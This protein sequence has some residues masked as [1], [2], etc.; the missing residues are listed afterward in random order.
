MFILFWK[1][2][3]VRID[4]SSLQI[5]TY[6]KNVELWLFKIYILLMK[7]N[8]MSVLRDVKQGENY[9]ATWTPVWSPCWSG[10][11]H[12]MSGLVLAA[13]SCPEGRSSV[14]W[15]PLRAHHSWVFR[16]DSNWDCNLHDISLHEKKGAITY[17]ST[18]KIL[19]QQKATVCV[20]GYMTVSMTDIFWSCLYSD[21]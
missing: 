10:L 4:F 7:T 9:S 13:Q 12:I 15:H 3:Y 18:G 11:V 20:I 1:L 2:S 6:P 5:R 19:I 21:L 14:V 17:N 8:C 16:G